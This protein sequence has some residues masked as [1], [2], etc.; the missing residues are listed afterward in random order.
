MLLIAAHRLPAPIQELT[1][2]PTPT[3]SLAPAPTPTTAQPPV[4]TPSA[5]PSAPA[6]PRFGGI[7]TGRISE[8][9]SGNLDVTIVVNAD[10][11]SLKQTSKHGTAIRPTT[12][13]GNTISWTGGLKNDVLWTL[14][15]NSDPQTAVVTRKFGKQNTSATFRRAVPGEVPGGPAR[16]RDQHPRKQ[17]KQSPGY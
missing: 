9:K 5:A 14:T 8:P 17:R 1:E 13:N 10:G 6:A 15:P 3:P 12:S 7:W 16:P 2:S 4:A 11:K